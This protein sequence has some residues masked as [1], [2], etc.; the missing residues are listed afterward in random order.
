M[1]KALLLA[2]LLAVVTLVSGTALAG[3]AVDYST[4]GTFT[5]GSCLGSGTSSVTFGSGTNAI[6]LTFSPVVANL[7]VPAGGTNT[8]FGTIT[9][10]AASSSAVQSVNGT[11]LTIN[12]FQTSPTGGT[13]A[14]VG[15]ITGT[16]HYS[17]STGVLT[18]TVVGG[19]A[20]IGPT[21]Y[22]IFTQLI[23]PPTGGTH[24]ATTLQ[25]TVSTNVPEPASLTLLGTAFL[26]GGGYVRR[27]FS[28]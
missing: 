14:F 17:S 15:T 21:T 28:I 23:S 4:S 16:I 13:G 26:L 20:N 22:Q 10:S 12:I 11:T 24:G 3:T 27:R 1:R 6:T 19:T 25:G 5:C 2:T 8:S 18:F 7:D 9:A